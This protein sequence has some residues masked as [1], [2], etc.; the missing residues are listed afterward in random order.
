MGKAISRAGQR[1]G[2]RAPTARVGVDTVFKLDGPRLRHRNP[3]PGSVAMKGNRA[4]AQQLSRCVAGRLV[5][6]INRP[7]TQ[8]T[9]SHGTR[10]GFLISRNIPRR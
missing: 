9:G 4:G 8:A 10:P 1:L 2:A 7:V 3:E 6:T 5:W